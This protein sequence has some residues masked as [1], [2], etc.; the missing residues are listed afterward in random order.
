MVRERE[1]P[2]KLMRSALS[3][4]L[5]RLRLV[6]PRRD[7]GASA[8]EYGLLVALVAVVIA[9]TVLALG[10]TLK[11]KFDQASCQVAAS[12]TTGDCGANNAPDGG[13]TE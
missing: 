8:V 6:R 11:N 3:R 9:G 4:L 1:G 12:A 5:P 13:S 2:V 7:D 10:D